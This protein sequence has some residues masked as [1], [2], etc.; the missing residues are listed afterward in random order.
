MCKLYD[1]LTMKSSMNKYILIINIPNLS[2]V[3][4]L[5]ILITE[6]RELES[7]WKREMSDQWRIV[8]ICGILIYY[9]II[10]AIFDSIREPLQ[11]Y[12]KK[13]NWL[14]VM[15]KTWGSWLWNCVGAFFVGGIARRPSQ[16]KHMPRLSKAQQCYE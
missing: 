7:K 6:A 10:L 3:I 16:T 13:W 15:L 2:H 8:R 1:G 5:W 11:C 14:A 9:H 12:L 4:W